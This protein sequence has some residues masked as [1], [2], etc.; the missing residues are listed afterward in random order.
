MQTYTNGTT[1]ANMKTH[2][3]GDAKSTTKN[4]DDCGW[5]VRYTVY[6]EGWAAAWPT[7]HGGDWAATLK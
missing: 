7:Y 3:E 2:P 5:T 6:R 1:S 4:K